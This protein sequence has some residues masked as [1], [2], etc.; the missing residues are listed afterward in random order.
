M[1]LTIGAVLLF[2][3]FLSLSNRLMIGNNQIASQNEYYIAGISLAQSIIDE[4]KTKAF[5]QKTV[6]ASISSRS[7]LTSPDSMGRDGISEQAVPTID[8]L[9]AASPYSSANKGFLSSIKFNDIDDYNLYSRVVNTQ[10]A[11]GYKLKV[12][13]GYTSETSPDSTSGTRTYAKKMIVK[14]TSPYFPKS[15]SSGGGDTLTLSYVYTY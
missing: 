7:S 3:A 2:G 11:E 4:G 9:T 14:V 13:V 5:D 1:I 10:R 8:T 15:S 12:T 6:S